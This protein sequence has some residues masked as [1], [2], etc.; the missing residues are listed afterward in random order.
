MSVIPATAARTNPSF[1]RKREFAFPSCEL[2]DPIR[3]S[4]AGVHL[5]AATQ[6]R[7]TRA[8]FLVRAL[9]LRAMTCSRHKPHAS[10]PSSRANQPVNSRESG[11]PSSLRNLPTT[12][13]GGQA[14][15]LRSSANAGLAWAVMRN[16]FR[17]HRAMSA[18]STVHA[19]LPR[20]CCA[21]S[22]RSTSSS[23]SNAS[24]AVLPFSHH[25]PLTMLVSTPAPCWPS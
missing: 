4:S 5:P 12:P 14:P 7:G 25:A 13:G 10:L 21:R 2:T 8:R 20:V 3:H 18:P 23:F 17:N 19:T 11:N 6:R 24:R 15:V 16:D 1:P 9:R 22:C